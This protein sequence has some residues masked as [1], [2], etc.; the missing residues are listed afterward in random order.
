MGLREFN[1]V[2]VSRMKIIQT[3][4]D[5]LTVRKT[6]IGEGNIMVLSGFGFP[7]G[8]SALAGGFIVSPAVRNILTFSVVVPP[9]ISL[10]RSSWMA[11]KY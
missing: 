7:E 11:V 1:C 9:Y 8:T 4:G 2:I 5:L 10:K 3:D 6:L